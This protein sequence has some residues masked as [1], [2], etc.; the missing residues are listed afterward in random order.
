[1]EEQGGQKSH[2]TELTRLVV[3][4]PDPVRNVTQVEPFQESLGA[5]PLS[6]TDDAAHLRAQH[7]D[8]E[9]SKNGRVGDCRFVPI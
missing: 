1:M 4:I 7:F 9:T 6:T 5:Q 3:H 8:S 2:D